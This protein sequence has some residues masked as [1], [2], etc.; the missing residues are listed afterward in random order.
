MEKLEDIVFGT[1]EN[2]ETGGWY[3]NGVIGMIEFDN[4]ANAKDAAEKYMAKYKETKKHD[5]QRADS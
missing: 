1:Q 2:A 4:A 5:R 3:V